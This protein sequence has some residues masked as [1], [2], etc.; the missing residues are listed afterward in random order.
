MLEAG[1]E[2]TDDPLMSVPQKMLEL[3]TSQYTARDKTTPQKH[4]CKS[5]PDKVSTLM[6]NSLIILYYKSKP[7]KAQSH[8][9]K[10][11][12]CV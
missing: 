10:R 3:Y 7:F 11:K 6:N 12:D 2:E 5:S 1:P 9:P 4:A 8:R